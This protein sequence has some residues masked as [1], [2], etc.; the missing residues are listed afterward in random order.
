MAWPRP[1]ALRGA[2]RLARPK[3]KGPE[4][5]QGPGWIGLVIKAGLEKKI[6]QQKKPVHVSSKSS[7]ALC[8]GTHCARGS[9]SRT[10]AAPRQSLLGSAFPEGAWERM[11]T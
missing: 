9:A 11:V 8:L 5:A 1:D 3:S 10:T 6:P 2:A 7:Q 4:P